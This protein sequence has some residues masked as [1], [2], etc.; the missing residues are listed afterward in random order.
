MSLVKYTGAPVAICEAARAFPM[1]PTGDGANVAGWSNRDASVEE[2]ELTVLAGADVTLSDAILVAEEVFDTFPEE[3]AAVTCTNATETV[4]L[5][6]HGF[7]TGDGPVRISADVLPTGYSATVEYWVI[8]TGSGTLKLATTRALA[9]ADTA[10]AITSD[11]T[12][13]VLH[14]VTGVKSTSQNASAIDATANTYTFATA[15]GLVADQVV[16]LG[17]SAGAIPTSLAADTDYFV[18]VVSPTVISFAATAGGAAINWS[19]G[20][21]TQSVIS[22]GYGPTE[23]TVYSVFSALNAGDPFDLTAAV[24]Y[25]ERLAHR[26][27][28]V[29]YHLVCTTD[30]FVA[31][32]AYVRGI[33]TS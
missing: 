14:W 25:R 31:I 11:G 32:T 15:H 24:A 13:P 30:L 1:P 28:V 26:P 23:A 6:A 5:T 3:S 27:E 4:N 2:F 29:A 10:Q 21:G 17:N 9:L 12:N 8:K 7:F 33:S 20:S 19:G 18:I 22:N 16:Q